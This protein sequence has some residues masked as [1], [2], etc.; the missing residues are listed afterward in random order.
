MCLFAGTLP[1]AR[2]AVSGLDP[3]V[4]TA[5]RAMIAGLAALVVLVV[6]GRRPPPRSLWLE[7]L[8]GAACTVVGF[9]LFAA[10]GMRALPASH[11]GVVLGILPLAT[12]AVFQHHGVVMRLVSGGEHERDPA[13][14]RK[15]T[16][17]IDLLRMLSD[18]QAEAAREFLPAIA[19]EPSPQRRARCDFRRPFID[20]GFRLSH[21]ARP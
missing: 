11:G 21:P 7:M 17:P 3:L 13:V 14:L 2:L 16:R 1:A 12:A 5:P 19:P 18:L 8:G 4:L 15:R 6:S 20:C 9:P 10:L